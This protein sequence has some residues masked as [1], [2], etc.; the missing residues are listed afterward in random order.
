MKPAPFTY[1]RP[2]DVDAALALLADLHAAGQHAKVL[3]GGQS[4][5]PL[6]SMR[7]AAPGHLVDV[8]ALTGLDR[9]DVGPAGVRVGALVRHRALERHDGASAAA[10][11]LRQAL[12]HVAH[13]TIRNRGTTVGSLCHADASGE[14]PAV[15]ALLGGS[16]TARSTRGER[17]VAAADFFVGPLESALEPDELAVSALFPLLP[18]GSGTAVCELARRHGDYAVCGV[19]ALVRL[20]A[21]RVAEAR[22]VYVSAGD[23][24]SPVD[25]TDPVRGADAQSAPWGD[26]GELARDVVATE[27]DIHASADYRSQLVAVLTE[28]ALRSAASSAASTP[29]VAA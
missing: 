23:D 2:A 1:H 9:V 13:P 6:L 21:G 8:N 16:V 25:L 7:L 11:L 20:E 18:S 10:P 12:Q 24:I 29:A 5:L 4:L 28:R 14:M 22:A 3:A 26:A 27:P 17:T 19:V 15:L